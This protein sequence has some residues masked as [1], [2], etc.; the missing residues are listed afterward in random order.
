MTDPTLQP[1]F[2]LSCI[3]RDIRV[4]W[5]EL[6]LAGVAYKIVAFVVL[7]PL[8]GCLFRVLIAISGSPVLSDVDILFFFLRP[9]GWLCLIVSGAFWL[10]IVAL[11]QASLVG[12]LCARATG[13]RL[14]A[15]GALRFAAVHA[16]PVVQVTARIVVFALLVIAP[17]LTVAAVAYFL[18]LSQYDINYYLSEKPPVF[19][20]ALGMA[21]GLCVV[22]AGLLLRFF[23][24]WFFALPLV[25]FEHVSPSESLKRS[26]ERSFGQRR[27]I[28]I[29]ILG[30][31]LSTTVVSMIATGMVGV[32]GSF[33]IPDSTSSLRV[34][35]VT[36]GMI[37]LL[38]AVVSLAVNLL[39]RMM[40]ATILFN[41]YRYRGRVGG[42]DFQQ[43]IVVSTGEDEG[44]QITRGRLL[45]AGV[46]GVVVA[47]GIGIL[48]LQSVQ[49]EDHVQVMAH[50]GSSQAAPENSMSA[51][52][53]AIAEGAD[54]VEIDVQETADGVV[55]VLHDSDFMKLA[56]RN[57]KIW[58]ATLDDLKDI[59]IGSRFAA[60][61]SGERVPT[62]A[63]VLDECRGKIGVNIELKY[64]GHEDQLEQRVANVVE[65]CE[66]ASDVMLMSLKMA[67]VRKMK[68]LRPT[69]KVGLL[70]SVSAGSLKQVDADF[71]AVNASFASRGLLQS[72]HKNEK[73]VYVWTVNDAATMSAMI[74]RGVDG[75]L[76]DKPALARAVLEQRAQMSGPER[77]LL[78]LAGILGSRTEVSEQ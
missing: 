35:E 52:R 72:A 5:K 58:D 18:M 20:I 64:Y 51:I 63:Q 40:F 77:L 26:R 21:A 30:W 59:D 56:G 75:L 68:S 6:L 17:F 38:W 49:L 4:C 48:V 45:A 19:L 78:E 67:G 57:L 54:W 33:L 39:G 53:K 71:L 25:L 50:R 44:F 11:E 69:W 8:V 1:R 61:F 23:T 41:L 27:S 42:G 65:S 29:W 7:T 36:V 2:I 24:D 14:G 70:M 28:P 74:S 37:L 43:K 34:L 3:I 15:I 46:L 10:A 31:V 47:S 32:L 13:Q 9:V 66:M 16:W 62:L 76:T 55:V 73:D 12:I 22:L 60:E